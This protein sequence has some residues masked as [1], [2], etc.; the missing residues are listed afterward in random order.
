MLR[1]G[2]DLGGSKIEAI[3]LDPS[4]SELLRNRIPTP[5]G[6]Y[7]ATLHAIASLVQEAESKLGDSCSI[8]ICIPGTLS[9]DNGLVKNANSVCLIGHPLNQ[10]LERILRR[11]IKIANDADCFTV[12]E[13]RD[14]AGKDFNT[15]FGVI[16]GTGVGG[17]IV[18]AKQLLSGPNRIAGEWGHNP[19]PWPTGEDSPQFDCYCGKQGCIET[20]LC[21]PAL[22]RRY[23][24]QQPQGVTNVQSLMMKVQQG[25]AKAAAC[26]AIYCRQLA[27]SL[28]SIINVL[29]PDII[30]LGGGLSNIAALYHQVPELLNDYVFSDRVNTK[31][32]PAL[33]GDSSGVRGAAWLWS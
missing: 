5:C 16:L 17:G 25:D 2:I 30:V 31:I 14:G 27:K 28:A 6:D 15:V 4:G 10:D 19:L 18:V 29:D 26:F 1:L 9:P 13:A 3:V 32:K 12:S 11:P 24:L 23:Q 20:Y 8:G 22:C 7:V 21:G 33:H